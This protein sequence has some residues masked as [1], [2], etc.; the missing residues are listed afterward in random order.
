MYVLMFVRYYH[1]LVFFSYITFFFLCVV[2]YFEFLLRVV[3]CKNKYNKLQPKTFKTSSSKLQL[4]I[5]WKLISQKNIYIYTNLNTRNINKHGK[6]E[7]I[8]DNPKSSSHHQQIFQQIRYSRDG[9][10]IKYYVKHACIKKYFFIEQMQ[11]KFR[12]TYLCKNI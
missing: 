9:F 7:R 5:L 4:I 10:I 11:L 1:Y 8:Y 12:L 3:I 2:K 6:C